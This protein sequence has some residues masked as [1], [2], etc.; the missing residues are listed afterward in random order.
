MMQY[1]HPNYVTSLEWVATSAEPDPWHWLTS[2]MIMDFVDDT[3]F[4]SCVHYLLLLSFWAILCATVRSCNKLINTDNQLHIAFLLLLL[5]MSL[6]VKQH[7]LRLQNIPKLKRIEMMPSWMVCYHPRHNW[8]LTVRKFK[9]IL[10][11]F[12]IFLS[13]HQP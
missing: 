1:L 2:T 7:H 11:P 8:K 9:N 13:R 3:E 10:I 5:A 4:L 12:L 6:K